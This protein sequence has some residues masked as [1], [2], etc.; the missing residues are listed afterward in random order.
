MPS[1]T[2][3]KTTLDHSHH[4]RL[5]EH[6]DDQRTNVASTRRNEGSS[7]GRSRHSTGFRELLHIGDERP[8][9]LRGALPR[10]V[11][12]HGVAALVVAESFAAPADAPAGVS[13]VQAGACVFAYQRPLE[14]NLRAK[15]PNARP[16]GRWVQ[17]A[18]GGLTVA[19]NTAQPIPTAA[20]AVWNSTIPD[21]LL[22][23]MARK[24]LLGRF[25]YALHRRPHTSADSRLGLHRPRC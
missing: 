14:L 24:G 18:L 6:I 7:G 21:S 25:R 3:S 10:P 16:A 5:G 23:P 2:Q 8:D 17:Q 4:R 20:S 19:P 13:H 22:L 11:D 12:F 1:S 9:L 15:N